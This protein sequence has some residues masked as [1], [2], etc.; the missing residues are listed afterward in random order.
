MMKQKLEIKSLI[1]SYKDFLI[2]EKGLS[3]NTLL[4]YRSDLKNAGKILQ[5]K[6]FDY[7]DLQSLKLDN[8]DEYNKFKDVYNLLVVHLSNLQKKNQ[9]KYCLFEDVLSLVFKFR[10]VIINKTVSYELFLKS[11]FELTSG[12]IKIPKHSNSVLLTFV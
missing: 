1:D 8:L 4:S 3:E 5:N 2:Y 11:S 12:K 10:N 6:K 7:L 9:K